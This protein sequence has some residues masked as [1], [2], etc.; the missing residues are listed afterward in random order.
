MATPGWAGEGKGQRQRETERERQ[1]ERERGDTEEKEE[2][3]ERC[4][5]DSFAL[6][7]L[8]CD[9]LL[10]KLRFAPGAW[11]PGQRFTGSGYA[12]CTNSWQTNRPRKEKKGEGRRKK[13]KKRRRGRRRRKKKKKKNG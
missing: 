3:E 9:S 12:F 1:R 4:F 5:K 6:F 13:G 8:G 2:E 10:S 11:G 7:K